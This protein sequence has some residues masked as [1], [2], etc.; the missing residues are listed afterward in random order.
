LA[1]IP[2]LRALTVRAPL[3]RFAFNGVLFAITIGLRQHGISAAVIG[4]IQGA[5]LAGGPAL[6]A[7]RLGRRLF[8]LG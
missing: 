2:L 7:R 8:F 6:P 4:L 3:V 5:N 1:P